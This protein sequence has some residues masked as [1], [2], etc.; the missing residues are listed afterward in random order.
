MLHSMLRVWY[1]TNVKA[2]LL[3]VTDLCQYVSTGA[4][5]VPR[6]DWAYPPAAQ[7]EQQYDVERS[8]S[9]YGPALS[10]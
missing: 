4:M 2:T 7:I 6:G 10:S 9:F 1:V 3:G 5:A 8:P